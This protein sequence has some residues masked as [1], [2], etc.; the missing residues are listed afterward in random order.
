VRAYCEFADDIPLVRQSLARQ[1]RPELIRIA[2]H[3]VTLPSGN[4]ASP[5]GKIFLHCRHNVDID[6]I[7]QIMALVFNRIQRVPVLRNLIF[8]PFE[9]RPV[10]K[11]DDL[12]STFRGIKEPILDRDRLLHGGMLHGGYKGFG[13]NKALSGLSQ[14]LG[15]DLRKVNIS[16]VLIELSDK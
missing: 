12:G 5:S 7:D 8:R 1:L 10:A 4:V 14:V 3:L 11:P 16:G 9:K 6:L 13:H 2:L 15:F